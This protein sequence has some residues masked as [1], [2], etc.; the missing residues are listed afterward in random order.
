M[1]KLKSLSQIKKIVK[2]AKKLGKRIVFTNGCFDLIHKGH[3]K[4]LK[5]A[6][7]QGD[8]LILGLNSDNSVRKLKGKKKPIYSQKERARILSHFSYVDYIIIFNELTPRKLIKNIVPDVLVKGKDYT[9]KKIVGKEIVEAKG[10]R[11]VLVP[12]LKGYSTT[13]LIRNKGD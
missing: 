13:K 7:K 3:I 12:L 5:N 1:E 10:G 11:V 2:K 8:I 4:L 6:K 9:N